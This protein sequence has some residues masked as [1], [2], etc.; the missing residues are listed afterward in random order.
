MTRLTKLW[1]EVAAF[2]VTV[3]AVLAIAALAVRSGNG[4]AIT[5][6]MLTPFLGVFVAFSLS[7]QRTRRR[8]RAS[9]SIRDELNLRKLRARG[10]RVQFR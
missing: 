1:F 9:L 10:P 3:A 8:D 2:T 7:R 5:T 4:L 6:S